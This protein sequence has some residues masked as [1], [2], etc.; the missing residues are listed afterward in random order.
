MTTLLCFDPGEKTGWARFE[1]KLI[2]KNFP[3]W[4]L[5][6]WELTACGVLPFPI[7]RSSW[8]DAAAS[9]LVEVPRYYH[10]KSKVDPN[11]LI[12]LALKVGEILGYYRDWGV[13]VSTVEPRTWKGTIDKERHHRRV[14]AALTT[15][16]VKLLPKTK[17]SKTN[18]HGYDNN[19]L[20]AVGMG[21]W[22]TDRKGGVV[23]T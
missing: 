7:R 18:P 3:H 6:Y 15:D 9:V 22:K 17:V 13:P 2:T 4:G 23:L 19:C 16:E 8:P 5:E 11:D 10:Q 20:D 21:L 14:L 1:Y 12:V